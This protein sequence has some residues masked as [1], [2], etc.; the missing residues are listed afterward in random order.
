MKYLRQNC[1]LSLFI[2]QRFFHVSMLT[3]PLQTHE[4]KSIEFSKANTR[5]QQ[6]GRKLLTFLY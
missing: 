4:A 3:L 6:E 2:V 5:M 1:Y